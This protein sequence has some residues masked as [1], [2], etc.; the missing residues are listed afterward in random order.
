MPRHGNPKGVIATENPYLEGEM[1][2]C[3]IDPNLLGTSDHR[4]WPLCVKRLDGKPQGF[5]SKTNGFQWL[6]TV[7]RTTLIYQLTSMVWQYQSQH[8]RISWPVVSVP[9]GQMKKLLLHVKQN[10][11]CSWFILFSTITLKLFVFSMYNLFS[12]WLRFS[13]LWSSTKATSDLPQVLEGS[14]T[15]FLGLEAF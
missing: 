2:M 5:A 13:G 9:N 4:E 7:A 8:S 6:P 10:M 3:V 14:R 12:P 15:T 11:L 1:I